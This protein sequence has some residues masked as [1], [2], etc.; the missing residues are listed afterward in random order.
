M[1]SSASEKLDYHVEEHARTDRRFDHRVGDLHQNRG[2]D[3]LRVLHKGA[4][5]DA[6]A[7][8][9]QTV[10]R[11]RDYLAAAGHAVDFDG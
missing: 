3:L 2:L 8:Y 4:R 11:I 10:Q 9:P 6:L 7:I 1:P 5:K